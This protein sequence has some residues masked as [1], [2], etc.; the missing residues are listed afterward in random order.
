[1][2]AAGEGSDGGEGASGVKIAAQS[3]KEEVANDLT[4]TMVS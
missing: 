1:M 3:A 2:S 4:M